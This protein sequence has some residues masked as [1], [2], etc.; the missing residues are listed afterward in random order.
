MG[1]LSKWHVSFHIA[2]HWWRKRMKIIWMNQEQVDN[3]EKNAVLHTKHK[4]CNFT[5]L[6]TSWYKEKSV[7]F[8]NF[9]LISKKQ[10]K[11]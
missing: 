11:A 6:L 5:K 2:L 7:E 4:D 1:N 8:L 10:I 3:A 9:I